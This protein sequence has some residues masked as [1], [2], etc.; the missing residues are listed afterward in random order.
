MISSRKL[1][2]ISALVILFGSFAFMNAAGAQDATPTP[3]PAH[4]TYEGEEGPEHWGALDPAYA[5]CASG[6]AQSPI[7][8]VS[9]QGV[10]LTDIQFDYHP[11]ALNEFNNGHTVQV[12]YD[13][14]SSITYN[15]DTYQLLQF[16]FHHESEHT[17]N[18]KHAP[19]ELHLVHRDAAGNLAVVG[20]M[21]EEGSVA[22]EAF[23]AVFDNL[24]D[25]KGTPEPNA[26]TVDASK[27]L[28]TDRRYTTYSGS[29]TTPPCTQGVRW[30]VLDTP[31]MVSAQ[32]IAAFATLFESDARPVQPLN[33]RDVLEDTTGA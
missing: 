14:G 10:D 32:Q 3:A 16:H 18:G 21:L 27:L 33:N 13:A 15:E 29:L 7:D 19:M 28:P 2:F 22:N 9:P 30:L 17:R 20:I 11:S 6:R 1:G 24:P 25:Q 5:M 4:W 31:V 26:L 8:L 23:A 12:N